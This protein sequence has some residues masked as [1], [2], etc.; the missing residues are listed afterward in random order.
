MLH[1]STPP[2]QAS[3]LI[4]VPILFQILSTYQP[5]LPSFFINY[6]PPLSTHISPTKLYHHS[7][8][9]RSS[10]EIMNKAGGSGNAQSH[11]NIFLIHIYLPPWSF[12]ILAP[13]LCHASPP[14]S[15]LAHSKE[16]TNNVKECG[17]T[18]VK[19]LT[20][21]VKKCD[22]IK[23]KITNKDGGGGNTQS[24]L[25]LFLH[26]HLFISV[27]TRHA[28]ALAMPCATTILR[29]ISHQE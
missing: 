28:P 13:S 12:V 2:T 16:P 1:H 20:N 10:C 19:E 3:W 9:N 8:C 23:G 29:L 22:R 14:Y 4:H 27:V 5:L 7:L 15:S 24:H 17:R 11:L 25:N 18:L 26:L 6:L 21:S